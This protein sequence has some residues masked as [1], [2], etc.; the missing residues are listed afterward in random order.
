MLLDDLIRPQFLLDLIGDHPLAHVVHRISA[1]TANDRAQQPNDAQD[2]KY[3]LPNI[4]FRWRG[5]LR[6]KSTV[7][8]GFKWI[9]GGHRH[10]VNFNNKGRLGS[11]R[12]GIQT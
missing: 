1:A 6:R 11:N 10:D 12:M 3:P 4:A 7:G 5:S 9:I 2:S 8:I